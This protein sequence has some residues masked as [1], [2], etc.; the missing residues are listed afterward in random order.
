MVFVLIPALSATDG[1]ALDAN[2]YSLPADVDISFAS[3]ATI[4]T[5]VLTIDSDNIVEH[6]EDFSVSITVGGAFSTF[7]TSASP[8][9]STILI[10]DRKY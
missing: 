8:S 4:S 10:R 6:W 2:D 7:A 9:S 1:R 3:G 5:K